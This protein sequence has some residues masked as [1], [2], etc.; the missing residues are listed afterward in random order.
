MIDSRPCFEMEKKES[1]DES[2]YERVFLNS[3]RQQTVE[4]V[5]K[6]LGH[7]CAL[8]VCRVNYISS[9]KFSCRLPRCRRSCSELSIMTSHLGRVTLLWS[10]YQ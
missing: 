7:H 8:H 9:D 5:E 4:P 3:D 1:A 2:R 10:W 6:A